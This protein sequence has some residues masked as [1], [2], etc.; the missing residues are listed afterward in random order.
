MQKHVDGPSQLLLVFVWFTGRLNATFHSQSRERRGWKSCYNG[1]REEE[2]G[3]EAE[4]EEE[5]EEEEES[6]LDGSED[7]MDG[8]KVWVSTRVSPQVQ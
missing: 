3:E 5:E 2:E 8:F 4:E 1:K 7:I 6:I